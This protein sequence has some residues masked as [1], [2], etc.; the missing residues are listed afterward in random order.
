[1]GKKIREFLRDLFGSRLTARLEE[2]LLRLRTD[3]ET[4]L[5]EKDRLIEEVR[6][7]KALLLSKVALYEL[8]LMPRAS[9]A[10]AEVVSA[11]KPTKPTFSMDFNSPPVVSKWQQTV[12]EHEEKLRKEE[13]EEQKATAAKAP[14]GTA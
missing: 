7:E 9:R 14:Q 5:Q 2:D 3:F 4:R 12:N 8:T 10:G 11:Q 6:A 1:M 13:E